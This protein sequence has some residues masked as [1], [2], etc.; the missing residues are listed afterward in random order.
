MDHYFAHY[1]DQGKLIIFIFGSGC[2]ATTAFVWNDELEQAFVASKEKIIE[3]IQ[4]GVFSFDPDL[5]TCLSTDYSKDD[6]GGFYSRLVSV[7]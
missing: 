6:M 3:M 1:N 2:N 7:R 4:K 5:E